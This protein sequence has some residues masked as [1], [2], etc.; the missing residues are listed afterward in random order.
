MKNFGL[1]EF[2]IKAYSSRLSKT[3]GAYTVSFHIEHKSMKCFC[4]GLNLERDKSPHS[5]YSVAY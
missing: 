2:R 1:L 3:V 4:N 5:F